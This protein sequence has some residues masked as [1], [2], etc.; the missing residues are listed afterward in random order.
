MPELALSELISSVDPACL[1]DT[2]RREEENYRA[3]LVR[4]AE[5]IL[6]KGA[7]VVLLAGPSASGKTTTANLL[8]D[9]LTS[10]GKESD[11]VSLDNFYRD[12]N[13]PDY[14]RTPSGEQ[15]FEC[16]ESLRI[17]L[18]RE[19]IGHILR[20]EDFSIPRFDFGTH[21]Y[22]D[23]AIP[24]G[25]G[26]GSVTVIEGL[27]ALN[28]ILTEGLP[29]DKLFGIFISVSTNL[30]LG[31]RRLLSGRKCR[32]IRRLTRDHL[33]RHSDASRTLS[34][35]SGVVDGEE[36]YLYPF[37]DRADC[38]LNTFHLFELSVMRPYTLRVLSEGAAAR[39]PY[40]LRIRAALS[41]VPVMSLSDVPE[42][43]LI[44]E[45]VPGGIYETLY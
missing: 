25:A 16:V 19:S 12:G 36:K 21:T 27:H 15:D 33:Y 8:S 5:A 14:P 26:E 9:L 24:V 31:D 1:A 35:W 45:F 6:K 23:G 43:S 37:R 11:V 2:V 4:T 18:I 22:E 10:M 39:D 32:F 17:P 40:A 7:R 20:G 34:L 3:Q 44:R 13:D 30:N 29:E 28:P 38:S 42:T 41:L